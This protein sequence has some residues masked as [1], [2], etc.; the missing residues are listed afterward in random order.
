MYSPVLV[1]G[2]PYI[3]TIGPGAHSITIG[4]YNNNKPQFLENLV[5]RNVLTPDGKD[6]LLLA[7]D[8]F[9]DYEHTVAGYPD[10]N[11]SQTVVSCYQYQ[12]DISAPTS[13]GTGTWD[14]HVF[15]LPI[16]AAVASTIATEDPTWSNMVET[17]STQHAVLGPLNIFTNASGSDLVPAYP[18]TGAAAPT[19]VSLPGASVTDLNSGCSRI[20][21][22][23]FEVTNTTAKIYKQGAVT[24]YRMPQSVSDVSQECILNSAST[25]IGNISMLRARMP[26]S[27]T[28]QANLLK[29]TRTWAASEGVYATA[30]QSS[31]AN[32]IRQLSSTMVVFVDP[33]TGSSAHSVLFTDYVTHTSNT[34]PALSALS[35]LI[36][37]TVPFDTTGSFLTGLSNETTLTVKVKYYVERAPTAYESALAVLAS[38]SAGYDEKALR[39][40]SYAINELPVAVPVAENAL[41]DWFRG[42]VRVLK[43]V[44]GGVSD[45]M[46]SVVPGVNFVAKP[47]AGIL[48]R[49]DSFLDKKDA[50]SLSLI[51]I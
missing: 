17:A 5:K 19:V 37:K 9:H 10:A 48:G 6:W 31:L 8:P 51:H 20:I 11:G 18:L 22:M 15:T 44:A 26:P 30:C 28:A 14:A 16:A 25:Q 36:E 43:N 24:S 39:L 41:G 2:I 4:M 7:L 50:Q 49:L 32:P 40:Y 47:A 12:T 38:P 42:V 33:P 29:G 27:T 21:G 46:G 45:V 35:P 23:A 3:T 13:A 34:A 1:S